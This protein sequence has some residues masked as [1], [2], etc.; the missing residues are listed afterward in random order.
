MANTAT[1]ETLNF[2]FKLFNSDVGFV[3][4][5]TVVRDSAGDI[6]ILPA[7]AGKYIGLFGMEYAIGTDHDL[8]L[9]SD[10]VIK[11]L[12]STIRGVS[13]RLGQPFFTTKKGEAL[14]INLSS[15]VTKM[16][17]WA[18]YFTYLSVR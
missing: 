18:Q 3:Q 4:Q 15:N 11:S 5:I 7:V 2:P 17:L 9:L 13:N 16:T 10:A 12:L 8:A 1:V 6:E 14:K